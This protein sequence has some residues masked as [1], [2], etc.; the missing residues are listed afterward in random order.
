MLVAEVDVRFNLNH[1]VG[2]A[3]A[4]LLRHLRAVDDIAGIENVLRIECLL[5]PPI[6][7]V[8]LGSEESFVQ[9]ATRPAVPM[10]AGQCP[11]VPVQQFHRKGS[12]LRQLC[13][14]LGLLSIDERPNVQAAGAGVGIIGH[15]R[16]KFVTERLQSGHVF[17][18]M[19]WW[20]GRVLYKGNGL[21]VSLDA[22]DETQAHFAHLPHVEL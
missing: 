4:Q 5:Y 14:F 1:V 19:L 7:F 18:Q 8:Q 17:G 13:H 10:F 22:H 15:V 2:G 20:N 3:E 9:P 21:V 16:S 12:D 11:L 6:Q